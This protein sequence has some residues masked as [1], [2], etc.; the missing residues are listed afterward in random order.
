ML[1][2]ESIVLLEKS[3]LESFEDR[4]VVSRVED[5]TAKCSKRECSARE[6]MDH[7]IQAAIVMLCAGIAFSRVSFQLKVP[8]C[9][10]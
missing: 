10:A 9:A 5:L 1:F 2:W 8:W 6:S 7:T 4:S 3:G